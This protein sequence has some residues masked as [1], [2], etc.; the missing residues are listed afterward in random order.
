MS[1][2]IAWC[3][4]CLFAMAFYTLPKPSQNQVCSTEKMEN[5]TIDIKAAF[6]KGIR[7]EDPIHASSWE[8]CVDV[9]CLGADRKKCNYVVFNTRSK[10]N[11][12]NCYLF[13]YPTNETF[14]VRHVSGLVTHRMIKDAKVPMPTP[15]SVQLSHPT[16]NGKSV[17]TLAA[18]FN[19]HSPTSPLHG[20]GPLQKPIPSKSMEILNHLD[21]KHIDEMGGHSQH[22]QSRGANG[23]KCL[24]SSTMPESKSLLSPNTPNAIEPG[25]PTAQPTVK[26]PAITNGTQPGT[27]IPHVSPRKATTTRSTT[28]YH[29]NA[30]WATTN[31]RRS[32]TVPN[33]STSAGSSA[34][35]LSPLLM[36][37]SSASLHDVH[38]GNG[39]QGLKG[40]MLNGEPS[41]EHSPHFGD[42]SILTAALLLGVVFFLFV[43]VLVGRKMLESLQRRRYTK[44]DYL[45][46]GMYANM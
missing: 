46:N 12:T 18:V 2:R 31:L 1:I 39:Q 36:K 30:P 27:I 23:S 29:K 42:K 24:G 37:I 22:P 32:T 26:S 40:D 34:G 25:I 4:A 45:I 17:S 10:G 16:V 44:L 43:T 28:A 7:G 33:P 3:S 20:S 13:Y 5:I 15:S 41:K 35:S 14:L 21:D 9:C 6:S 8:A 19:P 11:Y 38:L